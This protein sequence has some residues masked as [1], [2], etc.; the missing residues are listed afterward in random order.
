[1]SSYSVERHLPYAPDQLFDLVADV[2]RYPQFVP[3]WV[4]ATVWERQSNV[5]YTRQVLRLPFLHQEFQSRTTL[6]RP[7]HI[8][9]HSPDRPFRTLD[10]N[11]HF[12][13]VPKGG[14]RVHLQ[15]DFEF[16]TALYTLLSGFISEEGIR[17]LIDIFEAR[18]L[19]LFGDSTLVFPQSH[20]LT[21]V[22]NRH[23]RG[24]SE[25]AAAAPPL[26]RCPP[27]RP[28]HPIS[29]TRSRVM[30]TSA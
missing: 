18:A 28:A 29:K 12:T 16:H 10:M 27:I 6:N 23:A 26:L 5:Y 4:S 20:M 11:W 15:V 30:S 9:V 19:Q 17:H 22:H 24:L 2:E 3:W 25:N 8:Q 21:G 13:P 14:T 1:M 7:E